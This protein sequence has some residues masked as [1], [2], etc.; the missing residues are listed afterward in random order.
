MA[1]WAATRPPSRSP[2]EN[3]SR[4][5]P[6]RSRASRRRRARARTPES[7][8]ASISAAPA[9]TGSALATRSDSGRPRCISSR[10]GSESRTP[11]ATPWSWGRPE[12]ADRQ[13]HDETQLQRALAR[14]EALDDAGVL[15]FVEDCYGGYLGQEG[16]YETSLVHAARAIELLGATGAGDRAE[17]GGPFGDVGVF[18]SPHRP[19]RGAWPSAGGGPA[20]V[21]HDRRRS[22]GAPAWG[23]PLARRARGVLER[24][25]RTGVPG[26]A[27]SRRGGVRSRTCARRKSCPRSRLG[28]VSAG[29]FAMRPRVAS[30]QPFGALGR[31]IR[32]PCPGPDRR[33]RRGG[34]SALVRTRASDA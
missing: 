17:R 4:G 22:G 26:D 29:E 20:P 21:G 19:R 18:P 16:R 32:E 13:G 30:P 12:S 6:D 14:A 3:P 25:G 2:A 9:R 8:P 28:S 23:P 5:S 34:R 1:P 27:R 31:T 24:P 7:W 15:G 10:S 11:S 33:V